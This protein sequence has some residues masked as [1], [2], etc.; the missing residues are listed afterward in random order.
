MVVASRTARPSTLPNVGSSGIST[1]APSASVTRN[2]L[3][4]MPASG[5]AET[6]ASDRSRAATTGSGASGRAAPALRR[7]LAARG[8]G[9]RSGPHHRPVVGAAA[10]PRRAAGGAA[11][12]RGDRTGSATAAVAR[13][14]A[15]RPPTALASTGAVRRCR[16]PRSAPAAVAGHRARQATSTAVGWCTCRPSTSSR[17]RRSPENR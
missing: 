6:M 16:W 8:D 5:G 1:D 10:R 3:P 13:S 17:W 7:A 14:D 11:S 12:A 2:S 4:P 9:D 15:P